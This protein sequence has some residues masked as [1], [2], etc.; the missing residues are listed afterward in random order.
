M[1]AYVISYLLLI[2]EV[3]ALVSS[4]CL[5]AVRV[6]AGSRVVVGAPPVLEI[7]DNLGLCLTILWSNLL[8]SVILVVGTLITLGFGLLGFGFFASFFGLVGWRS[9]LFNRICETKIVLFY[10]P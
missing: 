10:F 7:A 1:S 9:L 4:F 3:L 8:P 2:L 6:V 5:L